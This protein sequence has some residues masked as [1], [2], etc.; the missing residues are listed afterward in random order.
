[1]RI[2]NKTIYDNIKMNLSYAS[3]AMLEANQVVSSQ[4]KI[5]KLSDDPV[6]LV[7]VLNLRSSIANI[8]Q[9][10]RNI[11]TGRSWLN[12]GESALIQVEDILSQTKALC[13]EMASAT[14]GVSERDSAAGLVDGYLR[15]VMSQANTQ[16]GGRY[17]FSGTKTDTIPFAFD[18]ETNPTQVTYEGNDTP[19][20]IKIAK[21]INVEVGRDGET[22]FGDDNFDWSDPDVGHSNIFKTLID[23]KTHLQNDDVPGIQGTMDKL[24]EHLETIR[25]LVSNTG[26]REIRLD[27][28]EK[29]IQDLNL[30]YMDRISQLEDV[31]I[32]EAIIDLETKELVYQAALASSARVMKLSLVDYI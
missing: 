11:S 7:S 5:N 6:G 23:L 10:E 3:S 20:K 16:V 15:Q 4:K 31:D 2:A 18:D 19:F 27:V 8:N 30:T 29:T 13:V 26:S 12:M 22:I 24:D 1:M 17:I 25:T 32:A 21:D 28:K 14:K 9:L